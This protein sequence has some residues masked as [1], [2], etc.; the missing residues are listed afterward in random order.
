MRGR[1]RARRVARAPGSTG[2]RQ[3]G[4]RALR[5]CP[6]LSARG[7][8]A[9]LLPTLGFSLRIRVALLLR[10]SL[11]FRPYAPVLP[12]GLLPL[13]LRFQFPWVSVSAFM[14]SPF[15]C[16]RSPLWESALN[17]R[18]PDPHPPVPGPPASEARWVPP[19]GFVDSFLDLVKDA[20]PSRLPSPG[21]GLGHPLGIETG[22]GRASLSGGSVLLRIPP[23]RGRVLYRILLPATCPLARSQARD[24]LQTSV[25]G[26]SCWPWCGQS[27]WRASGEK[28]TL[29][30][31]LRSSPSGRPPVC[32]REHPRKT[33]RWQRMGVGK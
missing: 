1:R 29:P 26:T 16:P 18:L 13:R 20:K 11:H 30:D 7:P 31:F 19:G 3:R 2:A 4:S 17:T 23:L 21:P 15:L 28:D 32:N 27:P 5:L 24:L 22:A 9:S 33:T 25:K 14:S 10:S 8:S 12:L 6:G